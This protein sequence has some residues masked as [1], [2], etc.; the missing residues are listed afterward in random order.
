MTARNLE[1]TR[2]ILSSMAAQDRGDGTAGTGSWA[3]SRCCGY[4][5]GPD[6]G[7]TIGRAGARERCGKKALWRG[8]AARVWDKLTGAT[9][10]RSSGRAL[11]VRAPCQTGPSSALPFEQRAADAR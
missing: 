7:T 1:A 9:A 8:L 2:D 11:S 6:D 10:A 3:R 4:S 5:H